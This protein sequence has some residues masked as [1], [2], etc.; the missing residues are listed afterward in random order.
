ML[1]TYT[2]GAAS[3]PHRLLLSSHYFETLTSGLYHVC[4]SSHSVLSALKEEA[5]ISN[6]PSESCYWSNTYSKAWFT[7]PNECLGDFYFCRLIL[8]L[9]FYFRKSGTHMRRK[10]RLTAVI[11]KVLS[12]QRIKL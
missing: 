7:V 12:F 8:I 10:S 1:T 11:Q 9:F 2:V 6:S 3:G 4:L 5:S